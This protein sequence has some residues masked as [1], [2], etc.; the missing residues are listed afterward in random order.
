MQRMLEEAR[1]MKVYQDFLVNTS[2][3][4]VAAYALNSEGQLGVIPY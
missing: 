1:G 3:Q 4:E 2:F